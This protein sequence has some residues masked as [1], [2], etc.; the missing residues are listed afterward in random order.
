[1]IKLNQTTFF[2]EKGKNE[3]YI[4]TKRSFH[5]KVWQKDHKRIQRLKKRKIT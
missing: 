1:M 2:F 4:L 3:M 5:H